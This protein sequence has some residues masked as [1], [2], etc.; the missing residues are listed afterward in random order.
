MKS[1]FSSVLSEIPKN[2]KIAN[3]L[4]DKKFVDFIL[5]LSHDIYKN[6]SISSI[7]KVFSILNKVLTL[8]VKI[9]NSDGVLKILKNKNVRRLNIIKLD[10]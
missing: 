6:E 7:E 10:I 4:D 9:S 1:L 3:Y 2:D 5:L 8:I